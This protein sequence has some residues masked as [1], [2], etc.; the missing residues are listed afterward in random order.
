MML[1]IIS[2]KSIGKNIRKNQNG[3]YSQKL[4]GYAKQSATDA[5]KTARKFVVEKTSEVVGDLNCNKISN[6]ITKNLKNL[7][8]Q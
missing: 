7:T 2:A 1:P 8:T 5:F 6:K 4:L 3:K